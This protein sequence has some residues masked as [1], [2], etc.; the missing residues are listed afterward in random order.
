M[1]K[2]MLLFA[3]SILFALVIGCTRKEEGER[4]ILLKAAFWGSHH[5]IKSYQDMIDNFEAKHPNIQV[6]V[7]VTPWGDHHTKM[8]T[9]FAG[10]VP[11]DIMAV[12]SV[13]F[14]LFVK[15]GVC[16]DITSYVERDKEEID[17]D[18]FYPITISGC[19][20]K[21]RFYG[22]PYGGDSIVLYYN[23][24]MFDREG[25]EYPNDSWTWDDF[26]QSAIKLTKDIDK[27][28][29]TDQ[30]GFSVSSNFTWINLWIRN[31]G[32]RILNEKK[33]K[34]LINSPEAIKA[35]QFLYDLQ[36]KYHVMPTIS[37]R[38][39]QDLFSN[40][41][42]GMIHLWRGLV[43]NYRKIP[44][45]KWDVGPLPKGRGKKVNLSS[46]NPRVISSIS[47]HPEEAWELLKHISSKESFTMIAR[48]GRNMGTRIS[49]D[50]SDAFLKS[51]PPEH[52][53]VFIDEMKYMEHLPITDRYLEIAAV[54][55][56]ELSI[57]F[58]KHKSIKE[59]CDDIVKKVDRMLGED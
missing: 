58:L 53:Q 45:F 41:R 34:C 8:L 35:I 40:G 14:P 22:L 2:K 4:K 59:A 20:H 18:D 55:E 43:V 54:V 50:N 1:K 6:E 27:D 47:K 49:V 44:D 11:V 3:L 37:E 30:F 36:H 56:S 23:K 17:L 39:N 31:N 21:G 15:K 12:S 51:C 7:M 13:V 10:R 38:E 29:R 25:V 28:G 33:N 52:N 57:A 46:V 48:V 32:G 16:L 9:M 26:R 42:L 19:K 5:Y 24:D